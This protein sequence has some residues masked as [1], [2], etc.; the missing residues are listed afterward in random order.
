MEN[1]ITHSIFG[2]IFLE[3]LREYRE[4]QLKRKNFKAVFPLW[5]IPTQDLIDDFIEQGFKAIAVCVD[6]T[7]LDE[8]FCGR[9]ID[10]SFINELPEDVDVCGENGEFHSFVYDAPFFKNPIELEIGETVAREYTN[11]DPD[12]SKEFYFCDLLSKRGET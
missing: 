4:K 10:E 8:S 5:Q 7:K 11:E 12:L 6:G 1:D 3:D 2:D 9:L